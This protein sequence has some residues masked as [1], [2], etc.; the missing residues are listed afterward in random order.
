MRNSLLVVAIA[1]LAVSTAFTPVAFAQARTDVKIGL[2][3]EPPSLDP[4]A[5]A[6][7]AAT[8]PASTSCTPATRS[9]SC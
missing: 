9:R 2:V 3:L 4:T 7:A 5:E 8:A 6:A 1:S